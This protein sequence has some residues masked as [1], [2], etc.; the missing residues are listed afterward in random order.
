MRHN[1]R[2]P[3]GSHTQADF[4]VSNQKAANIEKMARHYG[5]TEAKDLHRFVYEYGY[6]P[7]RLRYLENDPNLRS[8][9]LVFAANHKE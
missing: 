3:I 6:W 1:D 2:F 7:T 8:E 9:I 4:R 5:L